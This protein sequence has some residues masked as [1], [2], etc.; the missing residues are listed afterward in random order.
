MKPALYAVATTTGQKKPQQV[1]REAI[2][3][4]R[5]RKAPHLGGTLVGE[6]FQHRGWPPEVTLAFMD[7]FVIR[8]EKGE[9]QRRLYG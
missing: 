7:A 2:E 4:Y 5:A 9:I 1:A 8:P 6:R 3:D